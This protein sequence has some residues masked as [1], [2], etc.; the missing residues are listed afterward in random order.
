MSKKLLIIEE[1]LKDLTGHWFEYIQTIAKAAEA[2]NWQV[3]VACHKNVVPKIEERLSV[4]PIFRHAYYLDRQQPSLGSRYY[5]F[6]LHSWRCLKVL[7]LLLK[8]HNSYDHIFLPT[9]LTHHL[10]AWWI[11]SQFHPHK[12]KHLTLLFLT[13]PGVWDGKSKTSYFPKSS[14]LQGFLLRL[15]KK[16]ST[17]NNVTF[18][19]QTEGAKRQFES[20]TGLDFK[21]FPQPVP[22]FDIEHTPFKLLNF[23]CYGFARYEK[24][25]D[26]VQKAI[27][28]LLSQ[29]PEF[30]AQFRIQWMNSF[31]LPDGS[32]CELE[33]D[34]ERHQQ[35]KI[36]NRPL[37]TEDYQKLLED[38][39]CM[40]LPYRNSSYYARDSRI[41][42]E[43]VCLGIP[44]IYT[45]GGW[46]EETVTEFGAG[47]G[48]EDENS[49][50][51]I[52]A[53]KLMSANYDYY[54]QQALSKKSAARQYFSGQN[55]FNLLVSQQS[56]VKQPVIVNS[57]SS[58][59]S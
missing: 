44:V 23:A 57:S 33:R 8:Q 17:N 35:V 50:D 1:C 24:G 25:S 53:I 12:P 29:Q 3:D 26:L 39:G 5:G 31:T 2:D 7:W 18:A 4:F 9:V 21:L 11:L 38:T 56:T 59:V 34:F 32:I 54:R 27:A 22:M 16:L 48:I 10:I 47:I 15:F 36:I 45:K 49:A 46:L 52:A 51:L 14:L 43:A 58:L 6:I 30:N 41:T 40:I 55:F 37:L 19:V 20:L 42:I 13:N 28:E